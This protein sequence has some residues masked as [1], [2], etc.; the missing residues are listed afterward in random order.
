MTFA[1]LTIVTLSFTPRIYTRNQYLTPDLTVV[2]MNTCAVYL[3]HI[4]QL[5]ECYLGRTIKSRLVQIIL[6]VNSFY[7]SI[8]D[9]GE[10]REKDITALY[11]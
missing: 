5:E 4:R 8:S 1:N 6:L 9:F 7:T 10:I 11:N 2:F 3:K